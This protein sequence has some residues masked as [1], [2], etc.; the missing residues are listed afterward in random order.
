ML[1]L[2]CNKESLM[3][4]LTYKPPR[5]LP[6]SAFCPKC[7]GVMDDYPDSELV[8]RGI[9]PELVRCSTALF[10][11]IRLASDK[12][13]QRATWQMEANLPHTSAHRTFANFD[14]RRGTQK[15]LEAAWDF[16]R[17]NADEHILVL[18]GD[19]GTGKTF[20]LEAIGRECLHLGETVRYELVA[21]L[22]DRLR[23]VV[24]SDT[25]DLHQVMEWYRRVGVLLLDDLGTRDFSS[26]DEER[27]LMLVDDRY[28]NRG[29]LVVATNKTMLRGETLEKF[30]ERM[31]QHIGDR[32][33]SRLWDTSAS[34]G[35]RQA[36]LECGSY[37]NI[38]A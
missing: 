35:V 19:K 36:V 12:E 6:D 22:L 10:G 31:A 20:L 28:R 16:V 27:I 17:G 32:L 23:N 14:A 4:P 18:I 1:Y 37:R 11:C 34:G 15:A 5:A 13:G 3:R 8:E 38:P 30:L 2:W 21:E 24:G 26:F 29:R 25:E 9:R 7:R 33:A